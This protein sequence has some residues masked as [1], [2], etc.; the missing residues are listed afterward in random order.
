MIIFYTFNSIDFFGKTNEKSA[1]SA[2]FKFMQFDFHH[3]K[4]FQ[5]TYIQ[6]MKEYFYVL[7]DNLLLHKLIKSFENE[8]SSIIVENTRNLLTPSV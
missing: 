7:S 2:F 8:K 3:F 1:L 5:M 4:Y 6:N